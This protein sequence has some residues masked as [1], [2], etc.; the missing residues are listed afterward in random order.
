M[1]KEITLRQFI[2]ITKLMDS[3]KTLFFATIFFSIALGKMSYIVKIPKLV[4][5][6]F[7]VLGYGMLVYYF[8][9]NIGLDTPLD[10]VTIFTVFVSF[11]ELISNVLELIGFFIEPIVSL[12]DSSKY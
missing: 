1:M 4:A 11:L 3:T 9:R 7:K 2:E 8:Y 10:P 12:N 6:F 5:S